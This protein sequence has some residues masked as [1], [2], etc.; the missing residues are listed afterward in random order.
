[1]ALDLGL[2]GLASGFDWRSFVDQ[3]MEVERAPQKRLRTEQNTLQQVNNAFSSIKT[4]LGVL[5]NRLSGWSSATLFNSR[6]AS[7]SD[8]TV[9][10]AVASENAA[11]GTYTFSISQLATASRQVGAAG[12]G[13]PLSPTND[14]SSLVL[15]SAGFATTVTPG[16]FTVNGKQVTIATSDTL[17]DVFDAI[18]SATSGAVTAS[19]D[20]GSDQITL[21]S[22]G[23]IVLGSATDTSNFL[24]AAR[25]RN[26]GAGTITS[27]AALGA[28]RLGVTAAQ[29]N[30]ATALSDGGAGAGEFKINGVSIAFNT[31][32]DSLQNILDRINSSSAGVTASYDSVNDQFVLTNKSTGDVGMALEDVTGNFLAATGVST[33]VL[34]RGKDLIYKINNGADL[35]SHANTI[36]AD[37]SGLSG[38]SVTVLQEGSTTV[39]IGS[40]TTK[41]KDAIKQFVEAYNKAQSLIET[42]TASTTDSKGKV[43]AGVLANES[44]A[45]SIASRLRSLVY[46]EASGLAGTLKHLESL[47]IVS[48][49]NDNT[50]SVADEDK[51]ATALTNNLSE[52][53]ALFTDDTDGLAT[54]LDAYL[55]S[56]T[57]DD[58]LLENHQDAITKQITNIDTQIADLERIVQANRERM[59]ESFTAMETAQAKI[60]QQMQ[61]L[62][63]QLSSLNRS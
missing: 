12:A 44:E 58:G 31:A 61:Y 24:Q 3:L 21:A 45:S 33:G 32:Q 38:L 60:N 25:L 14:V 39:T 20:S 5:Q 46:S 51:L 23:E 9:G 55:E 40:D 48:N 34:S 17:Q 36:T 8:A 54:K 28:A 7:S 52:V 6:S 57:E 30:L 13:A 37:S 27:T 16:T 53:T 47:G 62:N 43:T 2:S 63:Q 10:T 59:L 50:L 56:L 18:N 49:G 11:I 35:F 41:I 29:S 15:S 22:A 26:N 19:Y 1:M 42:Q 4:E